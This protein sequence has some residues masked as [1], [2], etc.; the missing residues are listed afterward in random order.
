MEQQTQALTGTYQ[1]QA[2]NPWDTYGKEMETVMSPELATA[3]AEY[4]ERQWDV[5]PSTQNK[6]SLAEEKEL[7]DAVASQYQWIKP[8]EYAD[9]EQ[10]IGVVLD[11]AAFITRLRKAGIIC[12]YRQH[13]HPDKAVLYVN[14]TVTSE[15]EI[16]CWVQLGQAPELSIMNFD[17][18]GVPTNE[19]RR[20][21]R[22][23]L[24]QMILKGCISEAQANVTFGRPKQTEAFHRYNS[25]LLSFR[26][27]GNNL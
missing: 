13:P 14:R 12:H 23:C 3:V 7:S 10:R 27:A 8:E 19:R 6:E 16:A 9:L 15:P 21:W 1:N 25:T 2:V 22:T 18:H 17:N 20:G 26:N 24:L 11:H 4:A 5:K